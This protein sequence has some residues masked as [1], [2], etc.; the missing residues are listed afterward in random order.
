MNKK[1]NN[2]KQQ[3]KKK[4]Q[5]LQNIFYLHYQFL[6]LTQLGPLGSRMRRPTGIQDVAGSIIESGIFFRRDLVRK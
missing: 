1:N 4:K 2:K 6:L 5:Q 3:Q